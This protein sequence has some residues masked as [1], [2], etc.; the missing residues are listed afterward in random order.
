MNLP[1]FSVKRRVTISMLI[2]IIVLFGVISFR[3][4]GL[5]LMPEMEFPL[6][7]VVTNYE[8]V[9][10]EDMEELITKPL[11]EIVSTINKVKRVYSVSQESISSIVVEFEWGTNIDFAAQDVR[12]KIGMID[13]FLPDD[14][15]D[16]LVIKYDPSQMPVIIYGV[17]GMADTMKLR[18]YLQDNISP[19]IER[20]EG[21][22]AAYAI[23]G[24][25][26]EINVFVD[27][28]AL[29]SYGLSIDQ[30]IT[31]LRME[32]TNVSSGHVKKGYKEYLVRAL[33]EF[34]SL[35]D[36]ENIIVTVRKG[37]PVYLKNVARVEDTHKEVR[38]Y[39]RVDGKDSVIF[40]VMKQSGVN[41][42]Q[43][44][45]RVTEVLEEI[46]PILP[47]GMKFAPVMDQADFITKSVSQTTR[48]G[49]IGGVLA[50]VFIFLFLRSLRPTIIICMA[51]PL[52]IVTAFIGMYA[53]GYTFNIMTIGG[54]ALGIG[55]LVDNAVVVIENTFRHLEQGKHRDKA[56]VEGATEVYQAIT[57]STL[58]TMAV[59]LPMVLITGIAS[60][61]ARPMALTVCLTLFASLFVAITL[62]PMLA[63]V[64]LKRAVSKQDQEAF[65]KKGFWRVRNTYQK[66][67][68]WGLKHKAAVLIPVLV[69]FIA[70]L[71][72]IPRLGMEFMPTEDEPMTFF[73]LKMPVGTNLD[74]TD[75]VVRQIESYERKLPETKH[76]I[77]M[78]GPDEQSGH[79]AAQGFGATDQ[80]E[81]MI[82][83]RLYDKGDRD[84]MSWEIQEDIRKHAPQIE[85]ATMNFM[86]MGM[87]SMSTSADQTPVAIRIFGKDIPVLKRL[88]HQ[89]NGKIE[90]IEGLRD[91]EVSMREGKP[92]LHVRIDRQKASQFG[93]GHF[94]IA[95]VIRT[96]VQGYP[97]G[98][99]RKEGDEWD[100]R[101]RLSE[102]YRNSVEKIKNLSIM[103]PLGTKV[104]L[105][106][107]ADLSYGAGPLKI[108]RE[109]QERKITIAADVID[110]DI[111]S[112]IRDIQ[113]SLK[114]MPLPEGYFI[115]YGGSYQ[116]MKDTFSSLAF[117]LIIAIIL[118]YMIM[119]AQFE[120][121][122]QPFIVM[123]T[124][125]LGLIGVVVGLTVF[126][127]TLS[128][129]AFMGFIIL[130]GIT[131][132]NA[133][134][135]VD[136]INQL[137][138]RG[139][140]KFTAIVEGAATRLRPILITS[141]TT[142]LGILPMA[143]SRSE[144][145]EM[146]APLGVA[147][148]FGLF[149]AMFL[150]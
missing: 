14:A 81:A 32:N 25:T 118:V 137:R 143:L 13:E 26:R 140:D 1:E 116:D 22:A 15:D 52:S 30:F 135:M 78:V 63:S 50:A 130:C 34:R 18:K 31:I 77:T 129:T 149:F 6:V 89:V 76:V 122:A 105:F 90:N 67:L 24:L 114:D 126:R 64:F 74:E 88:A 36:I 35:E 123:F 127:F 8:G 91:I 141:F 20:K 104:S 87:S 95:S 98:K 40:A 44:V 106:Q 28:G 2:L 145:A 70:A 72:Y 56:A 80:N 146:R 17:T 9:A 21:V 103:S 94:Q 125:P 3:G 147:I 51:I 85:G 83:S 61:L 41:T 120:S 10:S 134:I 73:T 139:A 113:A 57:A 97:V 48:D 62:V 69:L 59:F 58:T 55:L 71:A 7:V 60:K 131:V 38:H 117:A 84:R 4:L 132:N 33:G 101:V 5:D 144:G 148:A 42:V 54:L 150:T 136:Y 11:E 96:S 110:R 37:K 29:E 53:F 16:P 102:E 45:N 75:R 66:A 43:V 93:L 68:S 138:Q 65:Q 115:D 39:T 128:T 111:G 100:I 86:S 27:R 23:G 12:N 109:N 107:V 119:A 124:V 19:R 108:S 82:F 47:K 46:K 92:E 142:I 99:F 121:L 79:S 49:A 133:I 112:V